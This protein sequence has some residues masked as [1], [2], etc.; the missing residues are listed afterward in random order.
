MSTFSISFSCSGTASARAARSYCPFSSS[1]AVT[2]TPSLGL[3]AESPPGSVTTNVA[4]VSKSS[5]LRNASHAS[6]MPFRSAASP[7]ISTCR[8]RL[9]MDAVMW[10][11]TES[12]LLLWSCPISNSSSGISTYA[13]GWSIRIR[14]RSALLS[15]FNTKRCGVHCSGEGSGMTRNTSLNNP[16]CNSLS[17]FRVSMCGS[18]PMNSANELFSASSNSSWSSYPSSSAS[19]LAIPVM[20]NHCPGCVL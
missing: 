12:T 19:M 9:K 8:S 1:S 4:V 5:T 20:G 15:I 10:L 11:Y 3:N 6:W 7:T 14:H 18:A 2:L 17:M 13:P 16:G